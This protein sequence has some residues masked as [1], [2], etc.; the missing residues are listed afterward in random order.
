MKQKQKSAHSA[1]ISPV[2]YQNTN[3]VVVGRDP[4]SKYDNARKL[5]VKTLDEEEFIKLIERNI[6]IK[7]LYVS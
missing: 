5:G 3:Y 2:Q 1:E 6:I 7:I 4:G